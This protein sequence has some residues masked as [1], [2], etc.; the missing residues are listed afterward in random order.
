MLRFIIHTYYT[1]PVIKISRFLSGFSPSSVGSVFAPFPSE[2]TETSTVD[3]PVSHGIK[4]SVPAFV[5]AF[6]EKVYVV[7]CSVVVICAFAVVFEMP[8]V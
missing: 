7:V 3:D 5:D 2:T 4:D 6:S 1:L 8:T